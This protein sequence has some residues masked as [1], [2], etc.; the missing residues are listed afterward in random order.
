MPWEQGRF[1]SISNWVVVREFYSRCNRLHSLSI[2]SFDLEKWPRCSGRDWRFEV[3]FAV[4]TY[5]AF[6]P[7]EHVIDCRQQFVQ[8][9]ELLCAV[10]W[11]I[12]RRLCHANLEHSGWNFTVL[13]QYGGRL[14][15]VGVTEFFH[16]SWFF[17][18]NLQI[19][20]VS[21]LAILRLENWIQLKLHT[22]LIIEELL[23]LLASLELLVRQ[24]E[25]FERLIIRHESPLDSEALVRHGFA[26]H[27]EPVKFSLL[28][29]LIPPKLLV[30]V[31]VYFL[32]PILE[33]Q[34]QTRCCQNF[35]LYVTRI[36]TLRLFSVW[37]GNCR[38][39]RVR[40]L[41][42]CRWVAQT[43]ISWEWLFI[44]VFFCWD[45]RAD[46][47]IPVLLK[48]QLGYLIELLIF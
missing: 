8:K 40:C 11:A 24:T 42:T 28:T 30:E 36:I 20:N 26:D 10:T 25:E 32:T 9:E 44:V 23:Q 18:Q 22:S 33:R 34:W 5:L 4:A 41:F 38:Y 47:F 35:G 43:L 12:V 2:D 21:T 7:R 6:G 3:A 39:G 15:R 14:T 1:M 46:Y 37:I 16:N 45:E 27:V 13:P 31:I 19:L 48:L 17:K 29:F